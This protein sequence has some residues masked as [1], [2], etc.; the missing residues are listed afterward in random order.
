MPALVI[1][2]APTGMV[3][4]RRDHPHVPEQPSEIAADIL[5]AA[6]A[7]ASSVHLHAQDDDGEPTYTAERYREVIRAVRE[8]APDLVISVS[9]SGRV[10]TRFEE[11]SAVVD[12]Y[13]GLRP[14]LASL[15]LGSMNFPAQAS[16]NDPAMIQRLACAM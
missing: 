11:R 2:I 4:R 12:L 1:T 6:G 8:A 13:D 14:D 3:P 10:H 9:T 7:G 16:V 5:A 15:T